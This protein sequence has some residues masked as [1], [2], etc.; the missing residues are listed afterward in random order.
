VGDLTLFLC[1]DVMTGRGID[2]VLPHPGDARIL[3]PSAR[4]AGT[5]VELAERANGPIPRPV[6]FSYPW[7]DALGELASQRPD[8]RIVNLETSITR[9]DDAWR[10]K[11]VHYRMHPDNVACLA[12]ARIDCCV[13]ANNH[14]LDY[15][16]SG[17]LET[18]ET[19]RRSGIPTA[20]AG[21]TAE[22]A[23]A[24]ALIQVPPGQGRVV[25]FGLGTE[26]SGI[27]P[28]WGAT[29]DRPGVNLL[30]DL[31]D[32]TLEWVGA[33]VRS[34]KRAGDVVVA[35]IHWGSNWGFDVPQAHVRFAHGLVR[36]GVD[37]VHGHSS[38]HV[39]PLEVFEGKLILYGCGDFLDDYEG[40]TGYEE[41]RDDLALMYFPTV[42]A[43]SGRLSTLRMTPMRI[44]NFRTIRA[45]TDDARWLRDTLD[46]ESRPFGARVALRA[47]HGLELEAVV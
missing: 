19:L 47:D 41:F 26:T 31:S 14:A 27:L 3:E 42:D 23:R 30:P 35:S 5:Y 34:V 18:L 32:E 45:S 10:G 21:R 29:D 28:S 15:G 36:A 1:G 11:D 24:P 44:R 33:M 13:L 6:D 12:A 38:H 37:I 25:V 2:Q 40:I 4:S 7:G 39:R 16:R 22:E 8:A 43:A 9:S 20:G 17:L 46:R